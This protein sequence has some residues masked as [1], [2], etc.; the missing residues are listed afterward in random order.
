MLRSLTCGLSALA[1]AACAAPQPLP[2]RLI[3]P[4]A[5]VHHGTLFPAKQGIE[6]MVN[7][8]RYSGFYIVA[9]GVGI[10]RPVAF[11]P[12]LAHDAVTTYTSNAARAHLTAEGAPPLNCEFLFD[13]P[14]AVGECRAPDGTKYQLVAEGR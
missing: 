6:A 4:A 14:R 7:G 5:K 12:F 2:F 13:G 8:H 11:G 3:D 10:S 1:L 9:S